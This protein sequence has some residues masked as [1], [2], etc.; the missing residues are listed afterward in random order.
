MRV[1]W[2]VAFL[3]LSVAC[4]KA[5]LGESCS[6]K[7]SIDDC[8]DGAICDTEGGKTICLKLCV[9]KPDCPADKECTGVSSSNLK[10]CHAK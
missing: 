5:E 2:L 7:G 3:A 9:D 8:V 6:T 1:L 10:A 4:G